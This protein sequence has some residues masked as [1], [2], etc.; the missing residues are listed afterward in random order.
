MEYKLFERIILGANLRNFY[1]SVE[2]AQNAESTNWSNYAISSMTF[3]SL[4]S[5]Y[6]NKC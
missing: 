6:E 2:E 1:V 4:K 5:T 3:I